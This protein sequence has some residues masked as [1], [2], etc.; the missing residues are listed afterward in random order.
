MPGPNT[1]YTELDYSQVL[2]QAFDETTDRLRVDAQITASLGEVKITDGT[3]D[4]TITQV[5]SKY[6]LDVNILNDISV[7]ISHLEDS[8]RLGDGTNFITSTNVGPKT[9]LDVS[10]IANNTN[11]GSVVNFYNEVTSV[12]T[13]VLTTILSHIATVD[14]KIDYIHV[15]GTNMTEYQILINSVIVDKTYTY[16]G[17]SVS[18]V[19]NFNGTDLFVGDLIEIKTIHNRPDLGTFNARLQIREF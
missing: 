1:P 14:S 11:N 6:G 15:A 12:A 18:Q 16:F 10:I 5:G 19:F 4:A 7:N 17:S 8:I 13:G 9:A 3:N 2:R